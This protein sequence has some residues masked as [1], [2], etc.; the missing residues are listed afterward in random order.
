M[1]VGGRLQDRVYPPPREK[2]F[3]SFT[4]EAPRRRDLQPRQGGEKG[5]ERL[6]LQ[7]QKRGVQERW[8]RENKGLQNMGNIRYCLGSSCRLGA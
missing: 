8:E 1:S 2:S 7:I 4:H 5:R 3:L 6:S